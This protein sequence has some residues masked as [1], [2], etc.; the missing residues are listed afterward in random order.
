MNSMVQAWFEQLTLW[1]FSTYLAVRPGT[2]FK[3]STYKSETWMVVN[4]LLSY[5]LFTDTNLK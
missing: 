5:Y 3:S 4:I 2:N 1:K